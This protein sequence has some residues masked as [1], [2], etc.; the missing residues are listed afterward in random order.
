MKRSIAK[1]YLIISLAI[2]GITGCD[3]IEKLKGDSKSSVPPVLPDLQLVQPNIDFFTTEFTEQALEDTSGYELAYLLVN[4]EF[5]PFVQ[6]IYKYLPF[7]EGV[8]QTEP[9]PQNDGWE[10]NYDHTHQGQ[11]YDIQVTSKQMEDTNVRDTWT[12]YITNLESSLDNY[13]FM[14]LSSAVDES[15]GFWAIYP[16]VYKD[17]DT[18]NS[19]QPNLSVSWEDYDENN[20]YYYSFNTPSSNDQIDAWY[21]KENFSGMFNNFVGMAFEKNEFEAIRFD[22]SWNSD[23][24]EG[25]IFFSHDVNPGMGGPEIYLTLCWDESFKDTECQF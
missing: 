1:I 14:D 8:N 11:H 24:K 10:W 16:L 2:F 19:W 18:V 20:E 17:A 7:L 15:G 12:L 22:I 5:N 13:R 3:I 9:E 23:T 4:T 6:S 25:F 21:G